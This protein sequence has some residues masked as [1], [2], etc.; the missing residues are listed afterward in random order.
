MDQGALIH[1]A[2]Y[3]LCSLLQGLET[4]NFQLHQWLNQNA[5][6]LY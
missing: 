1:K 5:K 3:D 4:L 6:T 2:I